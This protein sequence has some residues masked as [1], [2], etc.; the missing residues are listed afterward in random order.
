MHLILTGA[1]GLVGSAVLHH[2]LTT[3]SISTISILSRRPVPQAEGHPKAKVIIQKD[4]STYPSE[5][6]EQLKGA[7]GVVWAQG[8]SVTKVTKDEYEK[9]TYEY[10]LA[11]AQAFTALSAPKPFKFVYVSG[12]GATPNPGYL[13]AHFGVVKG[14][15]EAALLEL[16]KQKDNLKVFSVRPAGVDP[17]AHEEIWGFLPNKTGM[18]GMAEKVLLPVLRKTMPGMISPTKEL[19]RVL[20]DLAMGD[21]EA[22]KGVGIEGEGRTVRNAGLRRIAGL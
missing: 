16:G 6:L 15:A 7:E 13:T 11:A 12:E 4:F 3:P 20:T 21:G 5:V 9:I 8:I 17:S 18:A 1:T 14:R 2:M 22:L 10:P 19:A